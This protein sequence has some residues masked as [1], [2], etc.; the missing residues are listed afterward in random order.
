YGLLVAMD[1]LL[2][3]LRARKDTELVLDLNFLREIGEACEITPFRFMAGIQESLF[4][5]PRFQF[6]ADSIRRVKA[7]FEQVRIVREDMAYVVS[8]RLL[9]K[10]DGQ[11][12]QV[13]KHLEK[14]TKLYAAMAEHIDEYV[15]LFPIHPAYLEVF[16][17]VNVVEKRDLL[18]ALSKQME[19]LG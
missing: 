12:K 13:R 3:Y 2:D 17:Q 11:R 15:E 9:A 18:K 10:N 1:E 16:E 7:R 4:D 14:F 6:A 19:N 5:S 8:R